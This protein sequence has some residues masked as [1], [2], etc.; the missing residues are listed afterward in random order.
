MEAQICQL[1]MNFCNRALEAEYDKINT[2]SMPNGT[3]VCSIDLTKEEPWLKC[4]YSNPY[5]E[6]L[7]QT[8]IVLRHLYQYW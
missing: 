7:K 3:K 8:V 4:I 2:K 5:H 6:T 1:L